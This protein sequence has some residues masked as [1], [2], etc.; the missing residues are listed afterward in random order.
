[1]KKFTMIDEE[2]HCAVCENLVSKLG[3]TARDHCPYCL[4]SLH[5]D[6]TPGSRDCDCRGVMSAI[7]AEITGDSYKIVY[8]CNT[9]GQVKKNKAAD[10]DNKEL[11]IKLTA[12]PL[13]GRYV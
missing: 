10:D 2:F 1:M 12:N 13:G 11:L 6:T 4:S 9:C 3:Y 5:L 7:S 8:R